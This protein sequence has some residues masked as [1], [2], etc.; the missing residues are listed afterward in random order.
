[1]QKLLDAIS[2]LT[3]KNMTIKCFKL[4]RIISSIFPFPYVMTFK[5]P[6]YAND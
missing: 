1:M 3:M 4:L 5:K 2:S 6:P